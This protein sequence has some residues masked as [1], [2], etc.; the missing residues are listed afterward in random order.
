MNDAVTNGWTCL[1]NAPKVGWTWQCCGILHV[2]HAMADRHAAW[3]NH[4]TMGLPGHKAFIPVGAELDGKGTLTVGGGTEKGRVLV[5]H[6]T[7]RA[8]FDPE[9]IRP[10]GRPGTCDEAAQGIR[11]GVDR[12]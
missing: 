8:D 1:E 4:R 3:L 11:E 12:R 7:R 5:R 2:N 10:A 9:D 6:P